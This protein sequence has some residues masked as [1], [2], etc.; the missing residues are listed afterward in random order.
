MLGGTLAH[1]PL[2][3]QVRG[4]REQGADSGGGLVG[5]P[6]LDRAEDGVRD[7]DGEDHG[8]VEQLADRQRDHRRADEQQNHRVDELAREEREPR[9]RR[10]GPQLVGAVDGEPPAAS[11]SLRPRARRR[12]A[13]RRPLRQRRAGVRRVVGGPAGR[14]VRVQ[15]DLD[16]EV[17]QRISSTVWTSSRPKR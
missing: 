4:G 11:A 3:E 16:L 13:R 2:A 1:V 10:L 15:R 5:P 6:L 9:R 17:T 7:D 8:G 12:R 14:G